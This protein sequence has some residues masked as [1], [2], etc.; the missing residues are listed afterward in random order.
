MNKK[1]LTLGLVLALALGASLLLTATLAAEADAT[2][3]TLWADD[4]DHPQL[5]GRWFWEF[6]DPTNWSLTA[7][8]GFLRITTQ[9]TL[10]NVL[11]QTPPAGDYTIETRLF[12]TPTENFQQGG[13]MVWG[14][15]GTVMT[16]IR[17]YCNVPPPV[18]VGNGIYFDHI[19]DG[20]PVGSN[21]AMT[22][23][24]ASETYLRL[25]RAGDVYS[26]Y[27]SVDNVDWQFVGA[28]TAGFTSTGIGLRSGNNFT[29]GTPIPSDYDYFLLWTDF[30][31]A[32]YVPLVLRQP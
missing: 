31:H 5:N 26:G 10:S 13:L 30:P 18:C 32:L 20:L 14:E 3:S 15:E 1:G 24:T 6:E 29:G 17:A 21:Y 7:R 28:H 25:V 22:V 9:P 4:F 27:V 23:T 16:L 19:E 12:I 8:P 11:L 2:M